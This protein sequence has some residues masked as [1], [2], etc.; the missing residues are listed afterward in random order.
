MSL[1]VN[2]KNVE[3]EIDSG[4]AVTVMSKFEAARLFPGTTIH[5]TNLQLIRFCNRALRSLGFI[6]VNVS[7]KDVTK[8]LNIYIVDGKRK[9]LLGREWIR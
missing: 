8:R 1:Q 3:F 5:H 7:Y 2:G 9:P 6:K 4:A